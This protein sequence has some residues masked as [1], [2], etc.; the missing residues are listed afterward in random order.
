MSNPSEFDQ[1]YQD[2]SFIVVRYAIETKHRQ[3]SQV[4]EN[5]AFGMSVGTEHLVRN[6]HTELYY[7][8]T[9]DPS[10]KSEIMYV[11]SVTARKV[12]VDIALNPKVMD[13]ELCGVPLLLNFIAG[14]TFG[15]AYGAEY[16]KLIGLH[17]PSSILETFPGPQFGLNG[18]REIVG[19]RESGRPHLGLL[20]KPNVGVSAEFY[21]NIA[22]EAAM[23]GVD[24]IKEDELLVNPTICPLEKRVQAITTALKQAHDRTGATVL[25][26]PNITSNPWKLKD[27]A[28]LVIRLGA[29]ALMVNFVALGFAP[30]QMLAQDSSIEVPIHLHR[31]MHDIFNRN[32]T[33]ISLDVIT[34]LARLVGGDQI[35]VGPVIGG[36]YSSDEV[37]RYTSLLKRP[38]E[39][40]NSSMPVVSRS[41]TEAIRPTIE[42]LGQDVTILTDAEVYQHSKGI[43]DAITEFRANIEQ[44]VGYSNSRSL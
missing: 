30:V 32:P 28:H 31:S 10:F 22:Y 27:L 35:H 12:L 17:L 29:N 6:G 3:L 16:I 15:S 43:R 21:A 8:T 1:S 14:D 5:I 40:I 36:L 20:L 23:G 19:T 42:M 41:S 33:G 44:V 25:Y 24:F 13:I 39:H 7:P 26:A 9:F 37:I 4:I 11:Q 34:Q 38:M 2:S 18:I